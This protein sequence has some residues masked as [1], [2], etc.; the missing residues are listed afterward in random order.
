MIAVLVACYVSA[1]S[2]ASTSRRRRD[3]LPVAYALALIWGAA[4]ARWWWAPVLEAPGPR[5]F[6]G[7]VAWLL[8]LDVA[9]FCAE[10]AAVAATGWATF[11]G[12]SPRRVLLVFLAYGALLAAGYPWIRGVLLELAQAVTRPVA[13]VVVG[14]AGFA[15]RARRGAPTAAEWVVVVMGADLLAQAVT[16]VQW[17][18]F[19]EWGYGRPVSVAAYGIVAGISWWAQ[20]KR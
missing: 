13:A 9:V 7:W 14:A 6:Q 17:Q 20:R 12:T 4:T 2:A 10:A 11:T 8:R 15:Y 16:L 18:P 19:R 1:L 3:F 5:P